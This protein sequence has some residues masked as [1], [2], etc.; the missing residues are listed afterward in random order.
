MKK[1]AFVLFGIVG[2]MSAAM[3]QPKKLVADKILGIVGDR[4]I[5]YSDIQNTIG[6]LV[7]QGGTPPENAEC[8]FL[9]QALVSKV[10]MLQAEKDSLPV[11]D[12]DVEAELDQKLRYFISQY[13]S[14]EVLE[15]MAGKTVYQ[16]KDDARASVKEQK[17]AE[18]MQ[19]KI[20]ENVKITPTEVKAYFDKIHKDSL[21]FF[22][23]QVEIGQI[24]VYPKASRDLEKYVQ[25]ELTNYKKQIEAKQ[26]TF[27]QAASKYSED[28]ATEEQHGGLFSL[29]RNDK[30]VD[31]TFLA[32]AF[33]LKDGEISPVIKS[34]FGYHII[35]MVKRSGDDATVRHI[36]RM[37]P[38]TD[39][40]VNESITKLDSVRSKL[41][42]GTIDFNAAAGRYSEDEAAK[43]S[44][45]YI[46]SR[47]GDTY[48]TIDELGK[49]IVPML[50]KLKVGEYSQPTVFTDERGG[51]KGVRILYL[52][53][54]S[55]PHRM[56]VRDDYN[57]IASAALEQKKYIALDKWLTTHIPNYYIMVDPDE[58]S[59]PQLQKWTN[60]SKTYASTK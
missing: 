55:E 33:R 46:I 60:A 19:R 32:A 34:K 59:C 14:K 2:I 57:R 17:L 18:A 41:I 22:E 15:Q 56:N 53:S 11:T 36:L 6:D 23:T 8:S 49:D 44:G 29:N 54:R 4:I 40:E 5:L 39:A 35:M 10:L 20:V 42:A 31:P 25:D 37:A 30:N 13:G 24:V 1:I 21:P 43:F 3:A 7:R 16:I 27:E 28:K 12:E 47:D 58:A 45:P 48:N 38:I 9:E 52:K 50:D 51:K 26:I